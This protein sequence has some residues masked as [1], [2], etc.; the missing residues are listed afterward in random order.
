MSKV[1]VKLVGLTDAGTLLSARELSAGEV[2]LHR[3]YKSRLQED[4][5]FANDDVYVVGK[6]NVTDLEGANLCDVSS[7]D[8]HFV[9][10]PAGFKLEIVV[11]A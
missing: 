6:E 5:T 7:G 11:V 2:V 4:G 10:I 8:K 3:Y 1:T 9:R